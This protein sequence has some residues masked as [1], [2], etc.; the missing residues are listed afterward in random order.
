[1]SRAT[2]DQQRVVPTKQAGNYSRPSYVND[3]SFY[4]P[5]LTLES[6]LTGVTEQNLHAEVDTGPAV[7]RE[8][9]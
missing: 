2:D 5:A 7:G 1:M 6:L 3:S 9:W 4:F 8:A